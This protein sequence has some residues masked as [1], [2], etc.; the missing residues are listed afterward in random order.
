MGLIITSSSGYVV[1]ISH[2]KPAGLH[3]KQTESIK[4][5]RPPVDLKHKANRKQGAKRTL[6]PAVSKTPAFFSFVHVGFNLLV[7]YNTCPYYFSS[8]PQLIDFNSADSSPRA[9]IR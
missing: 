6:K 3:A 2:Y 1:R 4:V 8:L 5:T 7:A 9:Y